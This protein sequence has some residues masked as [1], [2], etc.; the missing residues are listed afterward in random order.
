MRKSDLTEI[1]KEYTFFRHL[2]FNDDIPDESQIDFTINSLTF[3][4]GYSRHNPKPRRSGNVHEISFSKYFLLDND[5]LLSVLIHEMIHLWQ[6]SHIKEDRYKVCS[7]A[8]AHDHVFVAKMNTINM[9]LARNMYNIKLSVVCDKK[10]PLDPNCDAKTPFNV[11][12]FEN[13]YGEHGMIKCRKKYTERIVNSLKDSE[14]ISKIFTID[15]MSYKFGL[16]SFESKSKSN[17]QLAK[18]YVTD[19]DAYIEYSNDPT[20][21][22]YKK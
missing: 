1:K 22:W 14:N 19:E 10:L 17:Y 2:L 13:S 11:V 3:A 21:I 7:H 12:F 16:L 15:T 4:V 18:D 5:D 6:D 9:I 20:V 8:I